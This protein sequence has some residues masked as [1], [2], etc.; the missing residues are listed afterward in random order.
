MGALACYTQNMVTFLGFCYLR[1]IYDSS[2]LIFVA[3]IRI[4][5]YTYPIVEVAGTV[6]S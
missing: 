1:I 5:L 6:G 2:I 3:L 4:V